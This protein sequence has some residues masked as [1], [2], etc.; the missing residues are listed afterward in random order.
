MDLDKI[1]Q[2]LLTSLAYKLEIEKQDGISQHFLQALARKL[3]VKATGCPSIEAILE[4]MKTFG[5]ELDHIDVEKLKAGE[6]YHLY[7]FLDVV[8]VLLDSIFQVKQNRIDKMMKETFEKEIRSESAAGTSGGE[9]VSKILDDARKKYG[10]IQSF[11]QILDKENIS[12]IKPQKLPVV[13]PQK[14]P[15][16]TDGPDHEKYVIKNKAIASKDEDSFDHDSVD[17]LQKKYFPKPKK[18]KVTDPPK[19]SHKSP[20]EEKKNLQNVQ[21]L[22]S[23][24]QSEHEI[25]VKIPTSDDTDVVI[26]VK[27]LDNVDLRN[28]RIHVRVNQKKTPESSKKSKKIV[29]GSKSVISHHLRKSRPPMFSKKL[30]TPKLDKKQVIE[31]VIEFAKQAKREEDLESAP[32]SRP[33]N[34]DLLSKLECQ[35]IVREKRTK[36]AQLKKLMNNL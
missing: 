23:A 31:R 9:E 29:Y 8:N 1:I 14:L 30:A 11:G 5:L 15:K 20:L 18:R 33:V 34:R 4:R 7:F 12:I 36:N 6:Q 13:K 16:N 26:K 28:K 22:Q 17:H 2:N 3:H 32:T 24:N 21:S 27:P 35:R 25:N 19:D 10:R